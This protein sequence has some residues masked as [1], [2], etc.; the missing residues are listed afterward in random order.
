MWLHPCT[1]T[2]VHSGLPSLCSLLPTH[3]WF[4]SSYLVCADSDSSPAP[5]KRRRLTTSTPGMRDS[6]SSSCSRRVQNTPKTVF[7]VAAFGCLP[8]VGGKLLWM[9]IPFISNVSHEGQDG[10][11]LSTY[12]LR[13]NFH[14][15]RSCYI[16]FQRR[17]TSSPG[18]QLQSLWTQ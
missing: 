5:A 8:E 12:Y 17:E 13:A 7:I 14:M 6:F 4:E 2:Y 10:S 3:T 9:K 16:S 18:T 1:T 11:H 15:T